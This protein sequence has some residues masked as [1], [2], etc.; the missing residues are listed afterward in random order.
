MRSAR[1]IAVMAGAVVIAGCASITQG[2]SQVLAFKVE[3]KQ[4]VCALSRVDDGELGSISAS[5]QTI[6]VGKDKDDIVIRCKASGYRP[7]TTR[8]V[9][10]ATKEGL[11]DI[12]IDFGITDLI[13]GAMFAYPSEVNIV[14]E[15]EVAGASTARAVI[16]ASPGS[17]ASATGK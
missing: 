3:P 8:L 2:T 7:K 11:A 10:K 13:T 4:A 9:S 5:A 16:P 12:L 15:K 1:Q 6:E 14:L 17:A